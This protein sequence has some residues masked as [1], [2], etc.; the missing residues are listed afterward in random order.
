MESHVTVQAF[1]SSDHTD[2]IDIHFVISNT[3]MKAKPETVYKSESVSA[4]LLD[5]GY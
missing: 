5:Y 2:I 1:S 4:I 3:L